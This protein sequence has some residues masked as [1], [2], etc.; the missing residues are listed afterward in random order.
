MV[1][2]LV[3]ILFSYIFAKHC[4][5]EQ[6]WRL[7]RFMFLLLYVQLFCN[8]GDNYIQRNI[9]QAY[10][11]LFFTSM[12]AGRPLIV[13]L[14]DD[15]G[16]EVK[17]VQRSVPSRTPRKDWT[18]L[19]LLISSMI[20]KELGHQYAVVAAGNSR[21]VTTTAV[22]KGRRDDK[23]FREALTTLAAGAGCRDQ[24]GASTTFF[25]RRQCVGEEERPWERRSRDRSYRPWPL[26]DM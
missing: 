5:P 9:M 4:H 13:S 8:A 3:T 15:E 12:I 23:G 26:R 17:L 16:C 2:S 24:G 19:G 11:I 21:A 10:V 20:R 6:P 22:G 18:V 25:A 14:V 7:Q 1:W